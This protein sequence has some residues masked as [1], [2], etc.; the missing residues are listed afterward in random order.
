MCICHL[1][2][3]IGH[4]TFVYMFHSARLKLTAWYLVIIMT[5]S[6]VFSLGFYNLASKEFHRIIRVQE[7]RMEH[8]GATILQPRKFIV[9]VPNIQ[10]LEDANNRLKHLLVVLNGIIFFATGA[11][12]YFLAGRTLRPI[13]EMVSEQRRFIT[14]ASHELRTPLT[15]LRSEIEVG[16][17]SKTLTLADAKKL[18]GSNLEDVISMQSLSDNLLALTKDGQ[19]ANR[20]Q[21]SDISLIE[22]LDSAIKRLNGSIKKKEISIEKGIDNLH[23]LGF[24]ENITELFVILLDNAIKYSPEKSTISVIAKK[25]D[26]TVEIRVIDTGGGIPNEDLPHIFD[27]FYRASKSRSKEQVSGYGLGLSIAKQIVESHG[28]SISAESKITKGTTLTVKLPSHE[29]F[30]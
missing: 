4:L 3:D 8:P 23:V 17:R 26:G 1:K 28:G 29:P 19:K 11:A 22:A 20:S 12:G 18:L 13:Q 24:P 2:F 7:F 25:R 21:M 16:L 10:D 9:R 14:D 15:S 27:R 6:I 30:S 5:I